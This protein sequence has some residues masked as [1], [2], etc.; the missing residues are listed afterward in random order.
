MNII[1]YGTKK[2]QETRRA[3][4]YFKERKIVYQFR[5]IAEKPLTA[6][7]LSN[8]AASCGL[9]NLVDTGSAR[10]IKR[11]LGFMEYDPLEELLEDPALLATPVIRLDKRYF[12]RPLMETLPLG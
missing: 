3:E 2:C 7:E 1:V 9:A 4:R 6:T 5:D 11:G 8:M 12:L 10:F